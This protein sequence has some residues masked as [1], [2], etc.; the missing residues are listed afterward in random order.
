MQPNIMT[1]AA[2]AAAATCS[3]IHA[4]ELYGAWDGYSTYNTVELYVDPISGNDLFS[5]LSP[6]A[7]KRTLTAAAATAR[8]YATR[9][10][11]Q[12]LGPV[13]INV[14]QGSYA[15][16]SGE[17]F[18]IDLPAR[19]ISIEPY[20]C[21]NI[22]P[23]VAP[24]GTAVFRI[25]TAGETDHPDSSLRGI[26]FVLDQ[27]E[28]GVDID[29]TTIGGVVSRINIERNTFTA[30]PASEG[31]TTIGVAIRQQPTNR[32]AH[33]IL[34]NR[35]D[36]S[37]IAGVPQ[38][39]TLCVGVQ[40]NNQ[41]GGYASTY[42]RGNDCLFWQFMYYGVGVPDQQAR[43]QPRFQS[44]TSQGCEVALFLQ[45]GEAW[46][47][48]DTHAYGLRH[49]APSTP[50]A[51]ALYTSVLHA[52][53]SCIWY[54]NFGG[55]A[56]SD[57][58]LNGAQAALPN[59]AIDIQFCNT[60][61]YTVVMP[62]VTSVTPVFRGFLGGGHPGQQ[63]V[64]LHL[65]AASPLIGAGSVALAAPLN[66]ILV[67]PFAFIARN[68]VAL[69]IDRQPRI[70]SRQNIAGAFVSSVDV[71]SDQ[72][73]ALTIERDPAAPG[74][75]LLDVQ[76]NLLPV[77]QNNGNQYQTRVN[78]TGTPN[79]VCMLYLGLGFFP[80]I[81]GWE[82]DS[83]FQ[84]AL[85]P[86][87]SSWN[88]GLSASELLAYGMVPLNAAGTNNGVV[89]NLGTWGPTLGNEVELFLQG[90]EFDPATGALQATSRLKFELNQR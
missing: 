34:D 40:E 28:V 25:N 23:I 85:L 6:G 79:S 45:D 78:V 68:D 46:M 49:M 10:S 48:N 36:T 29:F 4:Q 59:A 80:D 74:F 37:T 11:A 63:I 67:G 73:S 26:R 52:H 42:M 14:R 1:R 22:E 44:N 12:Y 84:H 53:N 31:G 57:I 47:K 62:P 89:I 64:D 9:G 39:G 71:G 24:S 77:T 75:E 3:L 16:I 69:D 86:G 70:G 30:I 32:A 76:G 7:S 2:I 13:T 61:D 20:D 54:P 83:V 5:G 51:I 33:R 65:A 90:A 55:V 87:G 17:T 38:L 19:G 88:L 15:P 82:N 41:Y 27:G 43:N 72:V 50:V 18:P 21:P 8:L 60:T 35:F 58:F 66:A 81:N 56:A